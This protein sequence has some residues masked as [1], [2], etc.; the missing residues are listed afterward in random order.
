MDTQPITVL[1]NIEAQDGDLL[2]EGPREN[3]LA[4]YE[5]IRAYPFMDSRLTVAYLFGPNEAGL[6]A[7]VLKGHICF[8]VS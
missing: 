4:L 2:I 7:L 1:D 6:Y 3:L 8:T 5:K